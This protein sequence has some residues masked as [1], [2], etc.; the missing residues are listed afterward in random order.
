MKL[1][2]FIELIVELNPKS[3]EIWRVLYEECLE[4]LKII[5]S[6]LKTSRNK[7]KK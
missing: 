4:I 5:V 3:K 7:L 6:A 1:C 2:F